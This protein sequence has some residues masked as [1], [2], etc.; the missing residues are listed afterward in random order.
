MLTAEKNFYEGRGNRFYQLHAEEPTNLDN[1]IYFA[2]SLL[3]I[4]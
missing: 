4:A 2:E 1:T 3:Y